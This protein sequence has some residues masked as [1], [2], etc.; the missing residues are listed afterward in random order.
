MLLLFEITFLVV[1]GVLYYFLLALTPCILT[2][3][4]YIGKMYIKDLCPKSIILDPSL[5]PNNIL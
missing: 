4:S 5:N 1:L 2:V 3:S